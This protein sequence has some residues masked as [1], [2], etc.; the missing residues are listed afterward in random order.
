MFDTVVLRITGRDKIFAVHLRV[1]HTQQT[2]Y[3][4]PNPQKLSSD[5]TQRL[6]S[7]VG[8]NV[9]TKMKARLSIIFTHTHPTPHS[10]K[11]GVARQ[12]CRLAGEREE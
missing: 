1:D 9:E 4:A 8:G 12:R 10:R 2:Q 7:D 3:S 11:S 6:S 5:L